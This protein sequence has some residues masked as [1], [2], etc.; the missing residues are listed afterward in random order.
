MN[1][2][3]LTVSAACSPGLRLVLLGMMLSS[4]SWKPRRFTN[5]HTSGKDAYSC[6][7]KNFVL[8][9][10]R[11]FEQ[12]LLLC[13]KTGFRAAAVHHCPSR[14]QSSASNTRFLTEALRALFLFGQAVHSI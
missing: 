2:S 7:E 9:A 14:S 3:W 10:D 1:I 6:Q 5:H 11:F 12:P 13:C 4:H 8:H